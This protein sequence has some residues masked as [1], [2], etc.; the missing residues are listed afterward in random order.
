MAEINIPAEETG[1]NAPSTE[2]EDTAQ[3][4]T[5]DDQSP[6]LTIENKIEIPD[7]FMNEDGSVNIENL[8]KSYMELEKSTAPE[9]AP[10]HADPKEIQDNPLTDDEWGEIMK[11]MEEEGKPSEKTYEALQ[12]RGMPRN[13]AESY[14]A[15]QKLL[16]EQVKSKI[17]A[18][19]GGPENYN[20]LME[21]ASNNLSQDDID[22]YDKIMFSGDINQQTLAVEGLAARRNRS[23]PSSPNLIMGDTG[24][25]EASNAFGSWDQVKRAM[26]DPRYETDEAYRA[27]V[28]Q[29]L[30]VSNI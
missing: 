16:A 12:S 5:T 29:R 13:M 3:T 2:A 15:G 10:E 23:D 17:M 27:N 8:A 11:E 26:R 1:P 24:P 7:K 30:N 19:V 21:W 25:T 4:T 18:P 9:P 28:T 20:D 14:I 22:S 6:D